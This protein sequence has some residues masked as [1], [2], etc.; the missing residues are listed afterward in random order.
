M[1]VFDRQAF[2]FRKFIQSFLPCLIALTDHRTQNSINELCWTGAEILPCKIDSLRNCSV[3]GNSHTQQLINTKPQD[4]NDAA[5][6]I[7]KRTGRV[8][9]DHPIKESLFAEGTV[10]KFNGKSSVTLIEMRLSFKGFQNFWKNQIRV[11]I[12]IAYQCQDLEG[13]LAG[14]IRF[15]EGT[16]SVGITV[17]CHQSA[18]P[19]PSRTSLS[20]RAPRAHAA[21][22]IHFLPAGAT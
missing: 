4:I 20:N 13:N 7:G 22:S 12:L 19:S 17:S 11:G 10:G 3:V 1:R 14:G 18:I 2:R 15:A 6:D 5:F 8:S 16:I 9:R 21:A